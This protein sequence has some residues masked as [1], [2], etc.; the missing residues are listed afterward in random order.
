MEVFIHLDDTKFSDIVEKISEEQGYIVWNIYDK[1]TFFDLIEKDICRD[2]DG[3]ILI[4]IY[5]NIYFHSTYLPFVF[6]LI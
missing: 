5:Y 6:E 1:K 3:R 4:K 2:K